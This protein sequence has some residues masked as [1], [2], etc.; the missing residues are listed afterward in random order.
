MF[1]V[2]QAGLEAAAAL[3][4]ALSLGAALWLAA[5]PPLQAAKTIALRVI[6]AA[7]RDQVRDCR[8]TGLPSI[9]SWRADR[10]RSGGTMIAARAFV[11]SC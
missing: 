1:T 8:F 10:P 2:P 4:A 7:N 5:P 3:A 6:P 9:V 11:N